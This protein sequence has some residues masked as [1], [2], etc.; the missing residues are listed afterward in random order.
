MSETNVYSIPARFRRIENLHILFWL[1]KDISWALEWESIG[2]GM[3]APTLTVAIVITWQTRH[4]KAELY[5][6]LAIVFWICANGFWMIMEFFGRDDLRTWTA[7]P[8]SIGLFFILTYYLYILPRE[9]KA[10]KEHSLT[11]DGTD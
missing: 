7:I 9:K 4:L 6:N 3:L 11:T 8:F 2:M 10:L 5:H 1:M